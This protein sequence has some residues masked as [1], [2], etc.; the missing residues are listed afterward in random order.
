MHRRQLLTNC[1]CLEVRSLYPPSAPGIRAQGW[2]LPAMIE[3]QYGNV[4]GVTVRGINIFK[5]I[6]YGDATE[7]S[8]TLLSAPSKPPKWAGVLDCT[9]N[10]PRCVQGSAT[11]L[12]NPIIGEIIPRFQ[13][14]SELAPQRDSENCLVLNVLTP[15][16][17]GKRPVMVYIYG[18]GYTGGSGLLTVFADR[19]PREHDVVLVGVNHR[20][21]V[22]GYLYLGDLNEKYSTGNAG[23]LDLIA[24][25]EWVATTSST[26]GR[27]QKHHNLGES[28]GGGTVVRFWQCPRQRDSSTGPSSRAARCSRL[29]ERTGDRHCE[30]CPRQARPG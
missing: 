5:G 28:G 13:R 30:S 18:G 21:N 15:G 20:L 10:G 29:Y 9:E 19:F 26:L 7:G 23:Q 1:C 27:S 12:P 11:P 8:G 6:P 4:R 16:T 17:K 2:M 22:F 24:A 14:S 3:T 25:L